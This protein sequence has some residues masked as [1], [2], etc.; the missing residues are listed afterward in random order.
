MEFCYSDFRHFDD[1][2]DRILANQALIL[3]GQQTLYHQGVK[4]MTDFDDLSAVVGEVKAAVS[5]IPPAIDKFE[6]RITELLKKIITPA[7]MQQ[8]KDA[9]AELRGVVSTADAA[10]ADAADETDEATVLATSFPDRA[11]FDAAVA[12]YTGVAGVNLD[13]ATVKG[14]EVPFLEYFTHSADGHIDTTGPTD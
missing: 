4:L 1:K 14:G 5:K 11:A 10:V 7:Q 3:S 6:A 2:L 8:V 12:A 13:G 9:V